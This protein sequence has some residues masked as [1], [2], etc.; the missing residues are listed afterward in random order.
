ML[1]ILL[2]SSHLDGGTDTNR[3]FAANWSCVSLHGF[4]RI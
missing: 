1:R 3:H 4:E 2:W